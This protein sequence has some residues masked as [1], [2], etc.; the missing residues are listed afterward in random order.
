MG[1]HVTLNLCWTKTRNIGDLCSAPILYFRMPN[2]SQVW[3]LYEPWAMNEDVSIILGGGGIGGGY[4]TG[5]LLRKV[6]PRH[7]GR[8]AAWGVGTNRGMT[9]GRFVDSMSVFDLIGIRDWEPGCKLP[10]VPCAS[11]M[12]EAFSKNHKASTEAVVYENALRPIPINGI[13]RMSNYV[14]W[15]CDVKNEFA[16]IIRFLA[17]GE[18]VVTSSYHGAY[19][20][21]LLGRK[22]VCVLT[23]GDASVKFQHLKHRPVF[24][25][26]EDW[27][28][29][30]KSAV[31]YPD[32][33]RE[34]R[35]ANGR[36]Y[37]RVWESFS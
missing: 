8:R 27:S 34:C 10:W 35:E 1:L 24:S 37:Q 36:F 7:P 19:W 15:K 25:S 23:D 29:R 13:P 30:S 4:K 22:V 20:A 31:C 21:T 6:I 17:S 2:P 16:R 9:L 5:V 12:E 26:I 32:S 33:L 28:G 14:P 18:T 3:H 11:C